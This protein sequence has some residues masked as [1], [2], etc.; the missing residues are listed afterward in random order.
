MLAAVS[1]YK[2]SYK[3]K[4]RAAKVLKR[5]SGEVEYFRGGSAGQWKNVAGE[6]AC[7][8]AVIFR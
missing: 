1:D 5:K 3:R 4:G 8:T 6:P 2:L 7:I